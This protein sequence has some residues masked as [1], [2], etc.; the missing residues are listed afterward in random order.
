M[1]PLR[2]SAGTPAFWL[3][4]LLAGGCSSDT[5]P[6]AVTGKVSGRVTVD[7]RPLQAGCVV[8]FLPTTAGAEIA[9]GLVG[10]NGAFIAISGELPGIPVGEYRVIVSPPP[11]SPDEEEA[12]TR[13]NS[14]AVMNALIK[15]S[16]EELEKVE[17]P[18][19]AIVPRQYW[20]ESTS[21]LTFVVQ[22]GDNDAP[23]QLQSSKKE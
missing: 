11:L 18:Q 23:F 4:L 7:G 21:G 10:E 3:G 15:Q 14:Q 13:K 22:E 16:R 19:D 2:M 12:L 8:T 20:R 9:S 17:Y 5:G 1:M 6:Q